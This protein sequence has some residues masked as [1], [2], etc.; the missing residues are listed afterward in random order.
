MV[1][2]TEIY[3]YAEITTITYKGNVLEKRSAGEGYIVFGKPEELM[4]IEMPSG[5]VNQSKVYIDVDHDGDKEYV[6][7]YLG[8]NEAK[9]PFANNLYRYL[10]L[11][12]AVLVELSDSCE[13]KHKSYDQQ[14]RTEHE[15]KNETTNNIRSTTFGNNRCIICRR[16]TTR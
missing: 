7:R 12:S 9:L 13:M 11:H 6:Y 8:M 16:I 10:I 14:R 5:Y 4:G 15:Q 1:T 2:I 3:S